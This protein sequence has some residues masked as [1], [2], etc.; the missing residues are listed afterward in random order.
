MQ[1]STN[2]IIA[3]VVGTLYLIAGIVGWLTTAH[4]GFFA[5]SGGLLVGAFGVN[6]FHNMLNILIGA[7]L[8]LAGLSTFTA[9]KIVTTLTGTFCLVLG[10]FGLF[11]IG[12]PVNVLALNGAD[13]VLHF[14]SAVL[15][16][17]VGMGAERSARND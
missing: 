8:L 14:A 3:T 7:A 16:L 6:S 1:A 4:Q 17:A 5:T 9:A 15:L 2:R 13:N 10:L 12:G 11:V